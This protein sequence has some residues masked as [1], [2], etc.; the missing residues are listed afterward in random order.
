MNL[1]WIE[2]AR[3]EFIR[4][5]GEKRGPAV[6]A[7]VVP[8]VMGDF[9]RMLE[10]AAEGEAIREEYRT[11]DG[12]TTVRLAGCRRG[13]ALIVTGLTVGGRAVDLGAAE[14]TL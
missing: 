1:I 4:V 14:L 10:R 5:Y 2:N 6:C 8:G 11:D 7:A 3:R 12:K 13:N 9:R